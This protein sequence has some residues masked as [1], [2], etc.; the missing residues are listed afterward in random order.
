MTPT[1]AHRPTWAEYVTACQDDDTTPT[2][3]DYEVYAAEVEATNA[4]A[5]VAASMIYPTDRRRWHATITVEGTTHVAALS[6]NDL[7]RDQLRS[8]VAEIGQ[9]LPRGYDAEITLW[10]TLATVTRR[11]QRW[12]VYR[13]RR[14]GAVRATR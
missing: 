1:A 4:M 12:T 9:F 3:A 14:S 10:K 5:E 2:W 8:A 13:D 7:Q 6:R 11:D